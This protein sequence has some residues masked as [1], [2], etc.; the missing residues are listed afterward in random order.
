MIEQRRRPGKRI[1]PEE[2]RASGH[3]LHH[4][5]HDPIETA[6]IRPARR[7]GGPSPSSV[8]ESDA[9]DGDGWAGHRPRSE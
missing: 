7:R 3:P 6:A 5:R 4:A 2:A 9:A 1:K 8:G